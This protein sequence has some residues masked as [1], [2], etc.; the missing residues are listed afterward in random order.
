LK[1]VE[2]DGNRVYNIEHFFALLSL[3]V[4]TQ[5]SLDHD[6]GTDG[7]EEWITEAVSQGSWAVGRMLTLGL[8]MW[9]IFPAVRTLKQNRDALWKELRVIV[10]KRKDDMLQRARDG[11]EEPVD[12]CLTVMIQ[13]DMPEIDMRDHLITLLSAGHDTTAYFTAY[14][15]YLL[16]G[17][18][19][20]QVKL[21][22]HIRNQLKGRSEI[23]ADDVTEMKYL[24]NVMQETLRLYSIIPILT[25]FSTEAVDIKEAQIH[26]PKGTNILIP[27]FLMNRDPQLWESPS[28][29]NPDRFEGSTGFFTSPRNGYFPFGYGSRTCIGNTL[30]QMEGAVFISKLLLKYEINEVEG[31]KPAIFAG[32]SLTTS[33]GINVKLKEL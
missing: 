25:R 11:I 7:K 13:E 14:L 16:G 15:C 31:F 2:N 18:K 22:E 26:I 32:I 33:N 19:D 21:R 12:D 27:M 23:T 6:F 20:V 29:F 28:T 5:F 4:F 3:R 30:A 8:P 10:Q 1:K 9:D 17:N 24:Q